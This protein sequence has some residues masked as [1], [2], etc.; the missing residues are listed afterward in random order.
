MATDMRKPPGVIMCRKGA[1][2]ATL[3]SASMSAASTGSA[4]PA[5]STA[6]SASTRSRRSS[7]KRSLV[8]PDSRR[9]VEDDPERVAPPRTDP[10]DAVPQID[11]VGAAAAL[12]RPMMQGEHDGIA[13]SERHEQIGR[14]SCR[15]R[16]CEDVIS[17]GGRGT[18][19][20]K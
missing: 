11:P 17:R 8:M 3:S 20:K 7:S 19:K 10:A 12:H 16:V 5:S 9:V 6:L 14:A 13:L 1:R 2:A 15:E 4:K 18:Y